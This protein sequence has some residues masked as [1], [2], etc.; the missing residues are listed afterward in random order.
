MV[1]MI[2]MYF[3]Q[4]NKKELQIPT[5][6]FSLPILLYIHIIGMHYLFKVDFFLNQGINFYTFTG[7]AF[8]SEK[9]IL[10]YF[11]NGKLLRKKAQNYICV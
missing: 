2:N 5:A 11:R 9:V 7:C 8:N 1:K 10:L 3:Y 4:N 6:H